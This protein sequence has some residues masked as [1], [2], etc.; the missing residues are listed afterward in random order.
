[1][2]DLAQPQPE[3]MAPEMPVAGPPAPPAW[4]LPHRIL[5]RFLFGYLVLYTAPTL[6]SATPGVSWLGQFYFKAWRV[7]VPWVAIHVFHLSGPATTYFP[8][9]S[10]DPTRK[11]G[12]PARDS[13]CEDRGTRAASRQSR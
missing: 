11:E 13:A 8:T 4:S 1:M 6:V 7:L 5:F 9:G 2:E 10:G 3:S 12:G